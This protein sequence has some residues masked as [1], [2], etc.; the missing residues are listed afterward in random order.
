MNALIVGIL[1]DPTTTILLFGA[2]AAA[3]VAWTIRATRA[4]QA[5]RQSVARAVEGGRL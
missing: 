1:G 2:M 3:E 4:G 5:L